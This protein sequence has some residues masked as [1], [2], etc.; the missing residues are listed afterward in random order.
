MKIKVLLSDF[1]PGERMRADIYSDF[2]MCVPVVIIAE[3]YSQFQRIFFA[4][5]A[6]FSPDEWTRVEFVSQ[7][8]IYGK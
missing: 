8:E 3:S 4:V 5:V 1:S 2:D 6:E 7:D